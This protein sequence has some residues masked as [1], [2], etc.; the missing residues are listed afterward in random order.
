[1]MQDGLQI[2]GAL[3]G[4]GAG[5]AG[6]AIPAGK[7]PRFAAWHMMAHD[8]KKWHMMANKQRFD[9]W[10]TMVPYLRETIIGLPHGIR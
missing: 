3:C 10:H 4:G 2:V 9:A 7:K 6:G 8:G 5:M 1:M